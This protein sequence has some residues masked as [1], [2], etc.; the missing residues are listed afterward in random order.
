MISKRLP[1]IPEYYKKYINPNVDLEETRSIC[2]PFHKEDTPSFSYSAELKRWR[3]FGSCKV[4]GD[5]I[6]LHQVNYKLKDKKE[7]L[8]SLKELY[9]IV[10]TPSTILNSGAIVYVD[11]ARME[12]MT[13]Y[14]QCVQKAR[15][16][17]SKALELD[18]LMSLS[19]R[20]TTDFK[21]LLEKWKRDDE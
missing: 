9:G 19:D 18:Y 14:N 4:G 20:S 16:D 21:D 12:N 1:T 6:K 10:D 17:I 7:A 3:C 11:E 13:L 8:A 2:C 15:E 5:V